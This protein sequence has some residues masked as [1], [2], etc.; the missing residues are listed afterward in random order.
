MLGFLNPATELAL[1]I[2]VLSGIIMLLVSFAVADGSSRRFTRR[3]QEVTS[4]KEGAAAVRAGEPQ[5]RSLTRRDSATP[6]IDRLFRLLPRR[7]LLVERLSRTGREI[8]VG[9]YMLATIAAIAVFSVGILIFSKLTLLPSLAF[10]LALGLFIPHWLIGRMG[11]RRIARFVALFPEAIDLMVRALRAGLPITEAIVNAGQEIGDP[12][13]VEFRGIEAGMRL[14]RDLDSLLWD[15]A[16]R[17]DVSEFRFFIIALS[18]QRET[19]GNLAETLNNLSLVLRGR[20]AMRAKARAMASEA[21]ASTAILGSLPIL[22]TIM[23]MFTSPTYI[24]PMFSDVRGLIMLGIAVGMLLS[25]IGIMVK[26]AKFE[27]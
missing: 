1:G 12:I 8:S 15:I 13:G 4:R 2:G 7:E 3:L 19:G 20:R 16:K 24:A 11:K 17:I 10:G 5:Q 14:G 6:G 23:L 27:I 21:R 25:G 18:V 22:V 9:Q 26:M